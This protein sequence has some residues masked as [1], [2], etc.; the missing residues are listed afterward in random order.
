MNYMSNQW[1]MEFLDRYER[2]V[3]NPPHVL[4]PYNYGFLAKDK[5]NMQNWFK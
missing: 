5:D 2:I 4:D 1:I 3:W